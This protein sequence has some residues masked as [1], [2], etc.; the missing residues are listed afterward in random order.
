MNNANL[1]TED[2]IFDEYTKDSSPLLRERAGELAEIIDA[3]QN[4]GGSTHWQVLQK[5][6]FNV[7]LDKAK[8]SLAKEKDTV[9]M[10]RLQGDIRTGEK[11][12]L[13]SLIAKYRNELLAIKKQLH[14]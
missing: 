5:Y 8:R 3:L 14:E 2:S 11:F 6:V 4:V 12:N 10:F 13:E 7:D 1:I 9:E